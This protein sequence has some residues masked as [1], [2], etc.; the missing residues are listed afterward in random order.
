MNFNRPGNIVPAETDREPDEAPT[1][2]VRSRWKGVLWGI[3]LLLTAAATLAYGGFAHYAQSREVA[4]SAE[5]S[6]NLVPPAARDHGA[7]EGGPGAPASRA[8][9][10]G[11]RLWPARPHRDGGLPG[12]DECNPL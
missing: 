5:Q 3:A 6:R 12:I 4:A 1:H 11:D 8:V 7:G 9:A 2:R 10:G